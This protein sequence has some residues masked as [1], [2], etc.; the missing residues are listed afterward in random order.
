M[1]EAGTQGP[2]HNSVATTGLL[3]FWFHHPTLPGL[4]ILLQGITLPGI[5]GQLAAG[6]GD[7]ESW[8][9]VCEELVGK[10]EGG[11]SM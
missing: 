8:V 1:G 4:G 2:W 11:C 10:G 6:Q 3:A 5:Y 7:H 9:K